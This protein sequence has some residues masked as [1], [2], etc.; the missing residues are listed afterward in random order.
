MHVELSKGQLNREDDGYLR[1]AHC[2]LLVAVPHL[3]VGQFV[4]ISHFS[5]H[6]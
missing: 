5:E 4:T 3:Q 1:E 2:Q 6:L